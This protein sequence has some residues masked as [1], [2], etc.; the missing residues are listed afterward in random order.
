MKRFLIIAGLLEAIAKRY[1]HQH[2]YLYD[3][4]LGIIKNSAYELHVYE[5]ERSGH[6]IKIAMD[7]R[8]SH[9]TSRLVA[10]DLTEPDSL[11]R[12]FQFIDDWL[13]K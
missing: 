13:A 9:C 1:R 6:S 4:E 10:I 2:Y 8:Y 3:E 5:T 7:E 12:I 11:D